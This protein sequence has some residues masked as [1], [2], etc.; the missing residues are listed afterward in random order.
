MSKDVGFRRFFNPD[1][2]PK[3][4]INPSTGVYDYYPKHEHEK[5]RGKIVWDSSRKG[6]Y[7]RAKHGEL[8]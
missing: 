5:H 6:T 4:Q 3:T 1:K 8:K 2:S 7:V